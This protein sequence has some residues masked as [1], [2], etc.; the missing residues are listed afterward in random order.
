MEAEIDDSVGRD[1]F[2]GALLNL[3]VK[4]ITKFI[5]FIIPFVISSCIIQSLEIRKS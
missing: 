1:L 4:L 2:F 3:F 5:V